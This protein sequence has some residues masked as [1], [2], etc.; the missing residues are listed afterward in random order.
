MYTVYM[1][2]CPNGKKYIGITGQ[3]VERRWNHGEGY[4]HQRLFYRAILKYGWNNIE[5]KII[6]TNIDK[7]E[8]ENIEKSL[9]EKYSTTNPDFGYNI[10]RGGDGGALGVSPSKETRK[11]LSKASRKSWQNNERLE[12]QRKTSCK[13]VIQYDLDGNVIEKFDSVKSACEKLNCFGVSACCKR[14]QK[15][16]KGYV[17]RFEGDTFEKPEKYVITEEHRKNLS[18]AIKKAYQDPEYVA[19]H[20]A[21]IQKGKKKLSESV[22]KLWEDDEYRKKNLNARRKL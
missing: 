20:N 1:H 4:S 7:L 9:I 18:S 10:T 8:A 11:K 16:C 22:K 15:T 17:F 5:H 12:K 13:K 14:K 6:K 2:I 19:S 3:Q 21:G